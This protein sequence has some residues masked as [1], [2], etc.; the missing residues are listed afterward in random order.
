[1]AWET[2][3]GL[4]DQFSGAGRGRGRQAEEGHAPE[5][6]R[7]EEATLLRSSSG[8]EAAEQAGTLQLPR[9]SKQAAGFLSGKRRVLLS[10]GRGG[11]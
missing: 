10:T 6:Q 4:A 1:M 5:E 11:T 9:L 2:A 8:E 7:L 3:R